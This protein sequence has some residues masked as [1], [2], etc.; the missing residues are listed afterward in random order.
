MVSNS[1]ITCQK[2]FF[3]LEILTEVNY[4]TISFLDPQKC[5]DRRKKKKPR[6]LL[7]CG[8]VGSTWRWDGSVVKDIGWSSREPGC[9]SQLTPVCNSSSRGPNTSSGLCGLQTHKSDVQTYMQTK[10]PIKVKKQVIFFFK[11]HSRSDL[12]VRSSLTF[13]VTPCLHWEHKSSGAQGLTAMLV[14]RDTWFTWE[15]H[16]WPLKMY[17]AISKSLVSL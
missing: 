10:P 11:Q 17:P 15:M 1:H 8:K 12:E 13:E 2:L 4:P 14:S 16:S 3:S 7:V 5:L 6:F 9:D